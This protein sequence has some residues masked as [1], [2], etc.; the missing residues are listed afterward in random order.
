AGA[1][2][3]GL[4]SGA[5]GGLGGTSSV[6]VGQGTAY[7]SIESPVTLGTGGAR[8]AGGGAIKLVATGTLRVDGTV[9]ADGGIS[10]SCGSYRSAAGGSLWLQAG[11]LV[12]NGYL[13]ARGGDSTCSPSGGGGRIAVHY[14]ALTAGSTLLDQ[15]HV[16][17]SAGGA[18]AYPGGAGTVFVKVT[19]EPYGTLIVDNA[20]LGNRTPTP[21]LTSLTLK[22]LT[23]RRGGYLSVRSGHTL[24]TQAPL[25]W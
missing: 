20:E 23:L 24:T 22:A 15:G 4:E 9:V 21:T 5:H 19:S 18:P 10:T 14:G 2:P 1:G 6:G 3:G 8:G 12:G 25:S 17:A 11:T 7:G 16:S 13:F